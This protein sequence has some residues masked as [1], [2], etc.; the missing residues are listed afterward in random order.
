MAR[1]CGEAR[2]QGGEAGRCAEKEAMW[3]DFGRVPCNPVRS[4]EI[5]NKNPYG[6]HIF[7]EIL[8]FWVYIICIAMGSFIRVRCRALL[9]PYISANAS[10]TD[11]VCECICYNSRWN[12]S[13]EIVSTH[14]AGRVLACCSRLLVGPQSVV[15]GSVRFL[16]E[17]HQAGWISQQ[18]VK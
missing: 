13:G 17:R 4:K 6:M 5:L 16:F 14:L 2:K 18:S 8:W 7:L 3:G 12:V 15:L 10:E 9:K 1:L 11:Q